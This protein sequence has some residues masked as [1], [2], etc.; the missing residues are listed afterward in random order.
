MDYLFSKPDFNCLGDP[1]LDP[2]R[3]PYQ[4]GC[5]KGTPQFQTAPP[6]KGQTANTVGY[7]PLNYTPSHLQGKDPYQDTYKVLAKSRQAGCRKFRTPNGFAYAS[8]TKRSSTPGDSAGTFAGRIEYLPNNKAQGPKKKID[9]DATS[10]RNIQIVPPKRGGAGVSGTLIG[11]Q[12]IEYVSSD[13]DAYTKMLKV[14][15][16]I[17]RDGVGQ[18]RPFSSV[19]RRSDLFDPNIRANSQ[20]CYSVLPKQE[21]S[22]GQRA[23][24]GRKIF[25][26]TSPNKTGYSGTISPFPES[27][28]EQFDDR[29]RRL[30]VLPLRRQPDK[31]AFKEIPHNLKD[32]KPFRPTSGQLA[33]A[34]GGNSRAFEVQ[35]ISMGKVLAKLSTKPARDLTPPDPAES[36]HITYLGAGCFWGT[37][38][39]F[40][41]HVFEHGKIVATEVG[42][43]G[44]RVKNP[45]YNQVCNGDTGHVEVCKIQFQGPNK[46]FAEM[47]RFFFS[48]HDSTTKDR[49]GNDH[50]T[51]YASTIFVTEER[52]R[53]IAEVTISELQAAMDKKGHRFRKNRVV[54]VV[55]KAGPFFAADAGHQRYLERNPGGT[56]AP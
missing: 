6:K 22:R 26:P 10:R 33:G 45:T 18:R 51:Q 29:E 9:V 32:R 42:F 17:H 14:E 20:P 5:A 31:E 11:G 34:S 38:K 40:R 46:M 16:K 36:V 50:G 53:R 15:H 3:N 19:T 13:Y 24:S 39:F 30:A 1:Y 56:R 7:G 2:P 12:N 55:R 41:R 44:G 28:P 47:L 4:H 35:N 37:E 21:D 43:M 52:Q 25:R 27:V 23:S 8:P 48:F 54:T 49:Q